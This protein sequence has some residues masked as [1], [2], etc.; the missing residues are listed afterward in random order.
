MISHDFS[1]LLKNFWFF[2]YLKMLS[3]F[4]SPSGNPEVIMSPWSNLG[5]RTSFHRWYASWEQNILCRNVLIVELDLFHF[6][7]K[8]IFLTG[9]R[10]MSVL[11]WGW[12]FYSIQVSTGKSNPWC[13]GHI[14]W[15]YLGCHFTRISYQYPL[16][17]AMALKRRNLIEENNNE[18]IIFLSLFNLWLH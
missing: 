8:C 5:K 15:L 7:Y 17:M 14:L 9:S 12:L 13:N 18:Q 1:S 6:L 10:V 16:K 3:H 4:S 11:R 2:P